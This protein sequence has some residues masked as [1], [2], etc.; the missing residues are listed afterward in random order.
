MPWSLQKTSSHFYTNKKYKASIGARNKP[1][2]SIIVVV[3]YRD[4]E[5]NIIKLNHVFL[6]DDKKKSC[7]FVNHCIL[8]LLTWFEEEGITHNHIHFWTDGCAGEFKSHNVF[9]DR[10]LLKQ[11]S[12]SRG[13]HVTANISAAD[14]GRGNGTQCGVRVLLQAKLK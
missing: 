4:E 9:M 6:S 8:K 1:P 11:A 10:A 12:E 5:G 3:W 13:A 2:C 14:M 7:E